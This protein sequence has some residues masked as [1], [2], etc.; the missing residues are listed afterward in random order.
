[1]L[2][3]FSCLIFLL[4]SLVETKKERK[5]EGKKRER[6]RKRKKRKREGGEKMLSEIYKVEKE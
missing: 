4:H 6:E 1:M 3:S 5:K 2:S